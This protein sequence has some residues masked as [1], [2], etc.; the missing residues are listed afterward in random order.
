MRIRALLAAIV[1]LQVV[2][3]HHDADARGRWGRKAKKDPVTEQA[4]QAFKEGTAAVKAGQWSE[5][6][7]H[8][9]KASELKSAPII[10]FNIGY[11]QRALGRYVKARL[12]F[13]EV[14]EEPAG[15]PA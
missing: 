12:S 3:L 9:E 7:A 5:A 14:V 6:L 11:C 10:T 8:F 4:R 1:F 2:A 13:R 15:M